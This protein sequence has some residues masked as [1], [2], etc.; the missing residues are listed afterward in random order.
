MMRLKYAASNRG[1]TAPL[2]VN[3]NARRTIRWQPLVMLGVGLATAALAVA[4]WEFTARRVTEWEDHVAVVQRS[5]QGGSTST[6]PGDSARAAEEVRAANRVIAALTIPWHDLFRDVEAAA[7]PSVS[8][9]AIQP[10]PASRALRITGNARDFAA[11][12]AYVRR[13]ESAPALSGVHVVRH[14]MKARDG[15]LPVEFIVQ[16]TWGRP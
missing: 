13:L 3:F 11:V 6:R 8:L 4:E 7:D 15:G 1:R 2:A 12:L 5:L 9:L 16:G 10:D 14:E